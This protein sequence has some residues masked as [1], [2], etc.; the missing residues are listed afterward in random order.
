MLYF[1]LEKIKNILINLLTTI[2]NPYYLIIKYIKN[3]LHLQIRSYM[4]FIFHHF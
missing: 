1:T 4:K 3:I 2:P